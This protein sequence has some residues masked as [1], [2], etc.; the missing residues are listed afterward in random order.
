MKVVRALIAGAVILLLASCN[1]QPMWNI[2]GKWK[3]VDGNGV[4]DVRQSGVLNFED[5]DISM[6]ARY[7][8]TKDNH[9]KVCM[10]GLGTMVLKVSEDQKELTLTDALGVATKFSKAK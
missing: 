7:I 2:G 1:L 8:F 10:G 3:Q 5:G 9:L 6:T 4:L